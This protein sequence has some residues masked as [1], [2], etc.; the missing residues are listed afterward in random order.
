MV[1]LVVV[2]VVDQTDQVIVVARTGEVVADKLGLVAM[3][4]FVLFGALV[5]RS[6][7]LIL[8][9]YDNFKLNIH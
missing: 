7:Q 6:H 8:L 4:L 1:V 5:E 3:V 9:T 2:V